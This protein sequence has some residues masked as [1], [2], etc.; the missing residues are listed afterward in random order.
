[1]SKDTHPLAALAADRPRFVAGLMSGTSLDGVDAVVV[2]LAGS[3]R[4]LRQELQAFV[5]RPY[6]DALRRLLLENSAPET[7]SVRALSQLGPRLA[8]VYA[9]AVRDALDEAALAPEALDLAGMHGQTVHHVP[10]AADCAGRAVVST[11]QLGDAATLAQALGV[12]VVSGFRQADMALGG[13]GAPLVPYYDYVTFTDHAETRGLLNLGGIANLT[14]LPAGAGPEAVLAFDTG[15]ANM[16]VD[17]LAERLFGRPYDDDGALA[18]EGT[19][20]TGLLA[21]LI[22]ADYFVQ[23]PPKSTGREAFGEGYVD[24]LV[25]RGEAHGL[26]PADLLAT[27]TALTA[28]TVYQAYA[29]FLRDRHPLDVLVASGGGTRNGHLMATL[30]EVFSPIPVR[31]VQDY[32]VDPDAK[33]A[34]CFAVLAHEFAN[35]VPTGM[36]AATGA[37]AAARL[38]QLALPA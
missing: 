3:G 27:A 32:G 37:T 20:H 25:R 38:G 7:S 6:P 31:T 28:Y 1:M 4:R 23:P 2:R 29:R 11:L 33:E 8:H 36:P 12:P 10:V 9:E 5:H 34:L 13:Q 17:Q 16:V 24:R 19:P 35:G 30:R 21:D 26:S 15:P 14:V 22:E 18:A